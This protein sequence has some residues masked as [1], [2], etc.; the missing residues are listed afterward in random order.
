M[1]RRSTALA[2]HSHSTPVRAPGSILNTLLSIMVLQ[3]C[4][5]APETTMATDA[6]TKWL[7]WGHQPPSVV[8]PHYTMAGCS[9]PWKMQD[10]SAALWYQRVT[11]FGE[12]WGEAG[13]G[14]QVCGA[15]QF[16]PTR[17]SLFCRGKAVF[18]WKIIQ[19]KL[20]RK[21]ETN[22][23][24]LERCALLK[25]HFSNHTVKFLSSSA[26]TA[27]KV[28]SPF[29]SPQQMSALVLAICEQG[30]Q[31]GSNEEHPLEDHCSEW[32]LA[33]NTARDCILAF[34]HQ[35]ELI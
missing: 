27:V 32:I 30:S 23:K 1:S 35:Q 15:G 16:F 17:K 24:C 5:H 28:H 26:Q 10:W 4:A 3:N 31:Q 14:G 2:P 25:Y 7:W 29:P 12:G 6:S 22:K 11:A 21:G 13:R 8:V 33:L 34:P 18:C 20:L 9:A 19:F